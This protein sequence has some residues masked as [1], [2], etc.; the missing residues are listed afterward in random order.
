M[1]LETLARLRDGRVQNLIDIPA[2]SNSFGYM[3]VARGQSTT[4]AFLVSPENMD[5]GL[6]VV[7]FPDDSEAPTVD[8][9]SFS[10]VGGTVSGNFVAEADGL[11]WITWCNK[12]SW[13]NGK[14]IR[15]ISGV[16]LF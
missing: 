9:Q 13:L 12:H 6:S 8:I 2:G 14:R 5:I 15:V 11:L 7:L 10:L 4:W 1:G 16:H 3:R